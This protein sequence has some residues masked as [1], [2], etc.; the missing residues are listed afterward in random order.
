MLVLRQLNKSVPKD[1]KIIGFDDTP[2]AKYAFPPLSSV[3]QDTDKI[4]KVAVDNLLNLI[5]HPNE[6]D[7]LLIVP[8]SLISRQSTNKP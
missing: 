7:Q 4:A 3:K 5:Q 2:A 6:T 8:V 1:I